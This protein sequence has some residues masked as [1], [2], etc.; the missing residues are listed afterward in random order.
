M[1]YGSVCSGIGGAECAWRGLGWEAVFCAEIEPFASA[2]LAW[3]Y[4]EVRNLG[5]FTRIGKGWA[6]DVLVGGTP[7]QSFSVAG[8]RGGVGDARGS[9]TLEFLRHVGRLK[10]RW[11]YARIARGKMYLQNSADVRISQLAIG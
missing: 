8:K 3:H 9:L 6:I 5:D 10:P 4:K 7:C 2:V 11:L 1:R